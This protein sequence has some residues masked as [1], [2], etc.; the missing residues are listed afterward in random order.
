MRNLLTNLVDCVD[1][2][3]F[4]GSQI[5]QKRTFEFADQ[6]TV[7]SVHSHRRRALKMN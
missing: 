1:P 3:M 2:E 4:T 6:N 5:T 7:T